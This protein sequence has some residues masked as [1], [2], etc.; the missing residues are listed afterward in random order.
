M[1]LRKSNAL[2]QLV[3]SRLSESHLGATH[4]GC[5]SL[6]ED[7]PRLP[8]PLHKVH[9]IRGVQTMHEPVVNVRIP[10]AQDVVPFL[11]VVYEGEEKVP[12]K[13][14]EVQVLW[15]SVA[16]AYNDTSGL[17]EPREKPPKYESISNIRN[18]EFIE[19]YYLPL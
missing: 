2:G 10:H 1:A 13:A 4:S 12:L 16:R 6:L 11:E 17:V 8:V 14:A 7:V 15:R 5:P 3:A 9:S 19:A 18:L